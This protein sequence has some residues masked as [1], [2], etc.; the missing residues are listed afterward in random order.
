MALGGGSHTV[1]VNFLL[2][3]HLIGSSTHNFHLNQTELQKGDF[4]ILHFVH[5]FKAGSFYLKEI[6]LLHLGI[7][8]P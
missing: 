5:T 8:F 7:W 2:T 1:R 6:S 4:L 3:Y